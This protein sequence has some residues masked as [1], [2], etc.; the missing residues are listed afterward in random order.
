MK[1]CRIRAEWE[2]NPRFEFV[3]ICGLTSDGLV[4][5][6][7]EWYGYAKEA[8]GGRYPFYVRQGSDLFCYGP[9]E[10]PPENTDLFRDVTVA[11]GK[12]FKLQCQN[13]ND[14]MYERK[15]RIIDIQVLSPAA[16]E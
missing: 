2:A 4:I 15:Y 6:E 10:L 1:I 7:Q 13:E 12:S 14:G 11:V 3:V 8:D 9:G 16:V 5:R